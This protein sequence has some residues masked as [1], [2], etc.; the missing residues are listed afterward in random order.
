MSEAVICVLVT[1]VVSI[2]AAIIQNEATKKVLEYQISELKTEVEK[3]NNVIDRTYKLESATKL[4]EEQI[5]VANH[6]IDD[7]EKKA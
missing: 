7:L 2:A 3:H 4:M 6:R 1:G 5:K